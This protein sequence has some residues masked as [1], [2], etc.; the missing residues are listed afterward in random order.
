M[1]LRTKRK[2]LCVKRDLYVRLIVYFG[3][4]YMP[5]FMGCGTASTNNETDQTN[6]SIAD[7]KHKQD[8][9]VQAKK[10][11]VV[12]A[13]RHKARGDSIA[14][15]KLDSAQKAYQLMYPPHKYGVPA[16]DWK[17]KE[18]VTKYGVPSNMRD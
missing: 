16:N 15:A 6:D 13:E 10:D 14:K 9:I 18:P 5:A 7:A 4:L 3:M 1:F 12:L 2:Y 8:S 11:S 17:P